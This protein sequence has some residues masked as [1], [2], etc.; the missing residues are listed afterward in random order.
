M[1]L[2]VMVTKTIYYKNYT[3]QWVKS[4]LKATK[5]N[6]EFIR[7]QYALNGVCEIFKK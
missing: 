6:L 4:N 2:L 3:G 5:A 7:K 1:K